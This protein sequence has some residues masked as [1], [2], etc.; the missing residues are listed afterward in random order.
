[1]VIKSKLNLLLK[2]FHIFKLFFLFFY[3]TGSV[4]G[5][6]FADLTVETIEVTNLHRLPIVYFPKKMCKN[7]KESRWRVVLSKPH[8]TV[9][10]LVPVLKGY[11]DYSI[12]LTTDGLD[13]EQNKRFYIPEKNEKL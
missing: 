10:D 11:N 4:S 13:I 6:S 12:N 2:R 3:I 5:Y 8:K 1:M 7:I 9:F